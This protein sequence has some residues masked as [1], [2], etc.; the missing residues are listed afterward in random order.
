MAKLSLLYKLECDKEE[1]QRVD[2]MQAEQHWQSQQQ[3]LDGLSQF[4]K[5]YFAQMT[6]KGQ[7]GL[8]SAGFTHYHN[9][10]AKIDQA[11]EQQSEAVNTAK[12]VAEQRQQ[13]WQQQRIKAQAIEKLMQKQAQKLQAQRDRAEQKMLDEF[14]TNQFFAR[15]AG[16]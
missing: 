2:Y 6:S 12:R 14:A 4:R 15:K 8:S 16:T 5:E 13:H 11:I 1:K 3:K 10:I 9:F 7:S